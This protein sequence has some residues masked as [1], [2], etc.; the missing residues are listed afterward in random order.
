MT[1]G[2]SSFV[3]VRSPALG[4]AEERAEG[5]DPAPLSRVSCFGCRHDADRGEVGSGHRRRPFEQRANGLLREEIDRVRLDE[6]GLER[7]W[8]Q[9]RGSRPASVGHLDATSMA[10]A[11]R[12]QAGSEGVH[13]LRHAGARLEP[14][15][16]RA[17]E[18]EPRGVRESASPPPFMLDDG[19]PQRDRA[20]DGGRRPCGA[21]SIEE[22]ER[23]ARVDAA[24]T[25]DIRCRV[26]SDPRA[27]ETGNGAPRFTRSTRSPVIDARS[28]RQQARTR[29][30]LAQVPDA[31]SLDRLIEMGPRRGRSVLHGSSM[32]FPVDPSSKAGPRGCSA[33]GDGGSRRMRV[34]PT[35]QGSDSAAR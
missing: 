32:V 19:A 2:P 7:P 22:I 26:L 25:P 10:R 11:E 9:R 13:D 33:A 24:P 30:V 28:G 23:P 3:V 18:S 5:V 6:S 4:P 1:I 27:E 21:R 12:V 31:P 20:H 29:S 8:V 14:R 16:H 35:L 15:A 34:C 17:D